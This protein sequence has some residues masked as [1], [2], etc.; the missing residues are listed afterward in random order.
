MSLEYREINERGRI[1]SLQ[2]LRAL[3]FFGIFFSHTIRPTMWAVLSV[4][5]FYVMSGF[6]MYYRYEEKEIRSSVKGNFLFAL[7]KI[8]KMYPLHIITLVLALLMNIVLDIH[9][10]VMNAEYGM[11]LLI[12]SLLDV[13]LLSAWAPDYGSVNGVAWFLSVTLFLYF[14]FPFFKGGIKKAKKISLIIIALCILIFQVIFYSVWIKLILFSGYSGI[15]RFTWFSYYFPVFRLGDF[16]IGCFLGR[17]YMEN[18]KVN[19]LKGAADSSTVG[20]STTKGAILISVAEL[21]ILALSLVIVYYPFDRSA[22]LP[23]NPTFNMTT[24]FIPL[25]AAWVY[26]FAIKKGILTSVFSN[27][28]LIF[29]GNYSP[30]MFLIHGVVKFYTDRLLNLLD[31]DNTGIVKVCVVTLEMLATFVSAFIYKKAEDHFKNAFQKK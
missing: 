6:L 17:V 23:I 9:N 30:Y 28:F 27:R 1:T 14:C 21:F 11:D 20:R 29:L 22:L 4:S 12:R 26:L 13:P 25:A 8:K 31:I 19:Y 2:A 16:V 24:L 7:S 10:N 18:T 3:A 5:V 15:S